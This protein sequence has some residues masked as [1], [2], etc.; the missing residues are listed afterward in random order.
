M[1]IEMLSYGQFEIEEWHDITNC[2][3]VLAK[4]PGEL[5]TTKAHQVM[6]EIIEL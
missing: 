5:K 1:V 2:S 4:K 6:G 3:Y